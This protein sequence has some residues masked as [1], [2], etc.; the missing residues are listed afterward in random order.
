MSDLE[1]FAERARAERELSKAATDPQ[2]AAVHEE[3]AA[4]YEEK[5]AGPRRPTLHV[6]WGISWSG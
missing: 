1:Y 6:Q 2:I 3:L 5:L 4:R